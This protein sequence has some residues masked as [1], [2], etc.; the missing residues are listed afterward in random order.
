MGFSSMATMRSPG[1]RPAFSAGP[2]WPLSLPAVADTDCSVVVGTPGTPR[3]AKEK[4]NSAAA[5]RKWVAEPADR[6]IAR[7]HAGLAPKVLGRS[8]S[9]TVRY[10]FIPA[11]FT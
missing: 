10:G 2:G 11:I 9:G 1:L 6:T 5:T 8:D 7:C 4:V 3:K